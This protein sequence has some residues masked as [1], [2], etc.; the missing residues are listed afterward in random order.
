MS[1]IEHPSVA[2]TVRL[3]ASDGVDV[4]FIPVDSHGIV[5]MDVLDTLLDERT[6]LVS[7]MLANNEIGTIQPV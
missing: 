5:R 6:A 7:V 3:L 2:E 1:A 4:K